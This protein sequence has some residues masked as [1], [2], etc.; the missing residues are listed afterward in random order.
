MD[1]LN[2]TTEEYISKRLDNQIDWYN[3]KSV[4]AQKIFKRLQ[5][6]EIV[7]AACI[8]ILSAYVTKSWVIPLLISILGCLIIILTSISKLEN[9]NE[10]WLRYRSNCELLRHEKYLFLTGASPYEGQPFQ[11]LVERVESIISAENINWSQLTLSRANK[12]K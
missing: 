7:L 11:L 9:Y 6:I 10:N 2:I 8:P 4:H 12:D 3:N 1:Y 5:S